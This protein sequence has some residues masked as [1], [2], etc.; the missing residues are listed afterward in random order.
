MHFSSSQNIKTYLILLRKLI[1]NFLSFIFHLK[2]KIKQNSYGA[3][4]QVASLYENEHKKL[5][6]KVTTNPKNLVL[7]KISTHKVNNINLYHI[8]G[9]LHT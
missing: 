6:S 8:G 7:A 3:N 1:H 2:R 5:K 9:N 4:F